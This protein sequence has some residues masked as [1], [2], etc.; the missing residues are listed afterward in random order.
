MNKKHLKIKQIT[1]NFENEVLKQDHRRLSSDIEQMLSSPE[2]KKFEAF[3]R[4]SMTHKQRLSDKF[5]QFTP[6]TQKQQDLY[7]EDEL[8]WNRTE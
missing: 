2:I 5:S 6:I 1:S 4:E 3:L 8:K 7:C